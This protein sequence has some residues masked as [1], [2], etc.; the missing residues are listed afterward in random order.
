MCDRKLGR[1]IFPLIVV[2]ILRDRQLSLIF[3]IDTTKYHR[4]DWL[5][6]FTW[7]S[8]FHVPGLHFGPLRQQQMVA[9]EDCALGEH[10]TRNIV[11]CAR[12]HEEVWGGEEAVGKQVPPAEQNTTTVTAKS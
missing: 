9:E 12:Y 3:V 2:P 6:L 8:L 11:C 4:P 10:E 7:T 5:I 1:L